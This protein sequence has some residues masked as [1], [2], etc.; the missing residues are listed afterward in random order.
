[1]SEKT[2][3]TQEE[4]D[5]AR[6][7]LSMTLLRHVGPNNKIGMGE[8]YSSV[9]GKP[10]ANR[11]NDTRKLRDLIMELRADGMPVMSD[12]ASNGGYWIAA[13]ASEINAWCDRTKARALS[14]LGRAANMKKVSL[15][16]YLG[17]MR[18]ELEAR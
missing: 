18:L 6:L 13:S 16:D 2:R 8:L 3:M 1:M 4:L 5:A 7:K 9:F 17:Q 15:P 14:M 12:C 11:I 10:W